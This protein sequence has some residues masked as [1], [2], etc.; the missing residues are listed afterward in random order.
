[1]PNAIRTQPIWLPQNDPDKTN[2]APADF[3]GQGGQPGDLGQKF[4]FNDRVYQRVLLDSGATSATPTGI[5][6][7]N[8]LLFW[9]NRV[10][11]EVTNNRDQAF[12]G[13]GTNQY[14][15]QVAGI[16][17]L[18]ATPGNYI[19]ILKKGNNIGILD[20][21]NTF[22]VGEMVFAKLAAT[23]SADRVGVG[24]NVSYERIG[25]ARGPSTGGVVQVDVDIDIEN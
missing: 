22:A 25:I 24:T 5:P 4:C 15:N 14:A 11:Y 7:A 18:A 21:G 13:S 17:R 2:I 6:A 16:L 20:G 3:T 12:G 23:A 1:M 8:Q 9:K 19:D 10:T